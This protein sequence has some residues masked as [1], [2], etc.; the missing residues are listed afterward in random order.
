[1][2]VC[3]C[4]A[5]NDRTIREHV[6]AGATNVEEIAGRCG[7]GARCGGCRRTVEEVLCAVRGTVFAEL[8]GSA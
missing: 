2:L 8:A 4:N 7:A 3:H 1:M 5:V 6:V